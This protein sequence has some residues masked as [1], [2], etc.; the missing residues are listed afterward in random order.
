MKGCLSYEVRVR[1]DPILTPPR[2]EELY[3]DFVAEVA[4]MGINFRYWTLGTYREKNK[5][6]DAWRER[7]GLPAMEWEPDDMVADGTHRHLPPTRRIE[8]YRAVRDIIRHELPQAKVSLCK[9]TH[10]VRKAVILCNA[11]CNCLR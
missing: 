1:V 8:I 11:D 10:E 5:Q 7:W 2:W 3:A 9:E 6:L 4:R